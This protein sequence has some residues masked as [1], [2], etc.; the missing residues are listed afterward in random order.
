MRSGQQVVGLASSAESGQGSG[1]AT[2]PRCGFSA[3]ASEF[4][5]GTLRTPAPS[6]GYVREG[7][8]LTVRGA[9][10]GMGPGL[11]NPDT[12]ISLATPRYPVTS[13]SDLL[14]SNLPEGG[15]VIR[16]RRGGAEIGRIINDGAWKA[17]YGSKELKPHTHQRAALA[18]LLGLWNAGTTTL[19]H[20]GEPLQPAPQQTPLMQQ[21]GVPAIRALASPSTGY[22]DGPRTTTSSASSDDDDDDDTKGMSPRAASVYKKLIAKGW[23]AAKAKRFAANAERFT[24]G[25]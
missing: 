25:K 12:G 2:C 19:Q 16:H 10:S 22:S 5:S 23:P 20:E 11:A 13:A 18:E 24:G 21:F 4:S 17:V 9:S 15:A 8:P 3:Q 14:V 7:A 6:T 1:M